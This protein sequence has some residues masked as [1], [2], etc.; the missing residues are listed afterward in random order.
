[1]WVKKRQGKEQVC[2]FILLFLD[3]KKQKS[4]DSTELAK[5]SLVNAKMF[6]FNPNYQSSLTIAETNYLVADKKGRP[7]PRLLGI[8]P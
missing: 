4:S 5:K 7:I 2:F 1:V 8:M 6:Q 3:E